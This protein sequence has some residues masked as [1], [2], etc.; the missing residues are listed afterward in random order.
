MAT[1]RTKLEQL[2]ILEAQKQKIL[3]SMAQQE[4]KDLTRRKILLGA[5]CLDLIDQD[6]RDKA[7]IEGIID[8]NLAG[9]LK[10]QGDHKVCADL[11]SASSART[12]KAIPK[13]PAPK[14]TATISTVPATSTAG[15]AA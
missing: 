15:S 5:M 8:R 12:G 10:S 14:H 6:A 2:A 9:Y 3:S 11:L 13:P 1:R 7:T 4:R